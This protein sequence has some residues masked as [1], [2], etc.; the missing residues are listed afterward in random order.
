MESQKLS[1]KDLIQKIST[2]FYNRKSYHKFNRV[3]KQLDE[4]YREGKLVA[5]E[6]IGELCF[7][8]IQEEKSLVDKF[9][10]QIIDQMQK[11]SCLNETEYKKGIH[12]VLNE[13]LDEIST[14]HEKVE[15]SRPK[16]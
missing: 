1:S 10:E 13:V 7:Y 8:F 4:K 2:E 5:Y 16:Y 9:R 12:D 3:A 11:N 15:A 14:Y 6:Y